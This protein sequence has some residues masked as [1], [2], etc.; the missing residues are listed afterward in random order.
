[1]DAI[2]AILAAV[3]EA[4]ASYGAGAASLI[5]GYEPEIPEELQER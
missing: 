2:L 3:I 5:A 4:I 1:M